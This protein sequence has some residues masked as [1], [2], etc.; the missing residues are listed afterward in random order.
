MEITSVTSITASDAKPGDIIGDSQ[1]L[2]MRVFRN[3]KDFDKNVCKITYIGVD[4]PL[5]APFSVWHV[6]STRQISLFESFVL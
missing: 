5:S 3:E 6:S 1:T 4:D 2:K